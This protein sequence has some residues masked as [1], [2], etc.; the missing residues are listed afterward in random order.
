M[1]L[2]HH[3]PEFFPEWLSLAFIALS[4]TVGV[5]VSLQKNKNN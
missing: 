3:F 1:L 2:I 4:I 5:L